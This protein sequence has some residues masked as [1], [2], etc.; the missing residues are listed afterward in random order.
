MGIVP[1]GTGIREDQMVVRPVGWTAR[2]YRWTR[3]CK[4]REAGH[5]E[6]RNA[7]KRK[8]SRCRA[9]LPEIV[10]LVCCCHRCSERPD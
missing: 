5:S 10:S 7:R 1:L 6:E 3:L 4:R 8:G 2:R 9:G